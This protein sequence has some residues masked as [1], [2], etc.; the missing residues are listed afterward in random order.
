MRLSA[1]KYFRSTSGIPHWRT[2]S[3]HLAW[4]RPLGPH[5]S[6]LN[7]V[8]SLLNQWRRRAELSHKYHHLQLWNPGIWL[9]ELE[10]IPFVYKISMRK[11]NI[12]STPRSCSHWHY[13]L[14]TY[15]N[16]HFMAVFLFL[17]LSAMSCSGSSIHSVEIKPEVMNGSRW[18]HLASA[19][20]RVHFS[21]CVVSH[22]SY[23]LARV[24]RSLR[25]SDLKHSKNY[26]SRIMVINNGPF[27]QEIDNDIADTLVRPVSH[28]GF[29]SGPQKKVGYID[30]VIE[31]KSLRFTPFIPFDF[32]G[33][34]MESNTIR[35]SICPGGILK[36]L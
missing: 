14:V 34:Q 20:N 11:R 23:Y 36:H 19:K 21:V 29:N 4:A 24:L 1:W 6:K 27:M 25:D 35:P 30:H 10:V 31:G 2:H 7:F 32:F 9:G 33:S 28:A 18:K 3:P 5:F 8:Y 13:S 16:I 12:L 17:F 15:K 26:S 22:K